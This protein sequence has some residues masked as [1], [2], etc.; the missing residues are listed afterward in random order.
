MNVAA[1][2]F[3]ILIVDDERSNIDVLMHILKPEYG[4]RVAKTGAA[5]IKVATETQPELILLDVLLPDMNGFE[6]LSALKESDAT[7]HI[8]V[9]FVTGLA[10]VED[11]ERGFKA[12]A[13][14]Y[15]VKPFNNSIVKARVRTHLQIVKQIRTIE[16]LGLIDPLTDIPNRRSF[17]NQAQVLWRSSIRDCEPLG[18]LILDADNFKQYNDTYGHPQ[19]DVLLQSVGRNIADCLRRPMDVAARIGGEEFAVLLPDTNLEG[20]VLVAESI[21][22]KIESCVV[23]CQHSNADTAITVSIGA[24]SRIA[25]HDDRLEDFIAEVDEK[26]YAAKMGGRNRVC[27]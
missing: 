1:E 26:M 11:E 2:R 13:V 8:P 21:R 20:A 27:Y 14:D 4:M 19:G 17:D 10:R 3:N 9:I 7:R 12:G 6:V 5:A 24:G 15:I 18:L 25:K 23:P 16:R 22:Q